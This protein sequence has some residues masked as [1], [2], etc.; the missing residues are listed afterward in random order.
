MSEIT[1]I[2]RIQNGF[3]AWYAGRHRVDILRHIDLSIYPGEHIAILGPSGAGKSTLLHVLGLLTPLEDGKIWFDDVQINYRGRLKHQ[4]FR[5]QIGF[6][7]EG[8]KLLDELNI[9]ENVRLPLNYRGIRPLRQKK[10]A[11]GVLERV[12]LEARIKDHPNRLNSG[13]LMRVAIA[14]ALVQNPRI[15]LADEPTGNL[16]SETGKEIAKLLFNNVG[17][18]KTLIMATHNPVLAAMAN[19]LVFLKDGRIESQTA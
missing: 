16:N 13:E 5:Q 1:P 7:F 15:I 3:K 18:D 11:Q 10:I 2:I 4:R 14:R 19:R 8:A 6:V 12:G 9:L 17:A